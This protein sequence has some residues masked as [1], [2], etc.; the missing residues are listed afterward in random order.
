MKWTENRLSKDMKNKNY[1]DYLQESVGDCDDFEGILKLLP[2]FYQVLCNIDSDKKSNWYTRMLVNVALSYLILENDL[3]PEKEKKKGY[4]DDIFICAY[5]LKEIRD[6]ISKEIIL[7][8]LDP[9]ESKENFLD[10]I[11]DVLTKSS[12]YLDNKTN[13]IL[14]FVGLNKF[15]LF[16]FLYEN[17]KAMN[18]TRL[19]KKKRLIYAML[20]VKTKQ[21][22]HNSQ[23]TRQAEYL[24]EHL[25]G[26][27]EF[28]EVRRYMEFDK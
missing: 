2:S 27:P 17:D 4:L 22:L 9:N 28:V 6:K 1:Y 14:E 12:S 3:I 23:Y 10:L 7:D 18:L 13:R 26:H 25:K 15:N 19:K 21:A 11:Y 5:V 16:D 8:N 20:A 24:K